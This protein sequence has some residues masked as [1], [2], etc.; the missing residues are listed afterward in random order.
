MSSLPFEVHEVLEQEYVAMYGDLEVP[1]PEYGPGDIIDEAWGRAVCDACSVDFGAGLVPALNALIAS[2]DLSHL[3]VSPAI[4]DTG[5]DLIDHYDDYT[6]GV[7]DARRREINRRIVDD[8]FLG[9][10]KLHRDTRLSALYKKLHAREDADARTALCISG[11]GIRT[12]TFA[13]GIIQG[14]AGARILDKFDYLSTVSGGGYIG[15]WL[16]SWARRHPSGIAGVQNDLV[17]A[18]TAV[19]GIQPKTPKSDRPTKKIDP[20][21]RPLRHLRAYSNYMSPKLG[22]LSAD[23]WTM[24]S[25]Y[26]RNLL[27]NLLVLIPI[28]AAV[29]AIPR[30]FAMLLR[31]DTQF[32]QHT[33]LV[34][35]A[36]ALAVG[37]GYLGLSRPTVHGR[38]ASAQSLRG[39]GGFFVFSV[40]P[41]TV[42][43]TAVS[44][45]WA[46]IAE[47]PFKPIWDRD[48]I[49]YAICAAAMTLLPAAIYYYRFFVTSSAAER[50]EPLERQHGVAK[51]LATELVATLT[52]LASVVTLF[53]LVANK[54]FDRPV[55]EVPDLSGIAP[56]LRGLFDST[57]VSELYVCFAVPIGLLIFF[58][59]NAAFVG[60]SSKVNEDYDREW[61]GRGG[62]LLLMT[63]VILALGCFVAVFGPV[64]LYRA[65]VIVSSIGGVSGI[66][67]GL[68]GFSSSTPANDK[69]KDEKATKSSAAS[70]IGLALAVPLFVIALLAGIS[71]G[72][73]VLIQ[74]FRDQK[75]SVA[76]KWVEQFQSNATLT[77][78]TQQTPDAKL[79]TKYETEKV[80]FLSLATVNG[81]QHLKT[82]H[83]TNRWDLL[84]ILGVALA[85]AGL[86]TL[87]GVNRFS[88]Q[89]LYRNRLIR[90]YLGASRYTRDAD[91]FTGF[92][93]HDNLQMYE[94]QPDLLWP[95]SFIDFPAFVAQLMANFITPGSVEQTIWN[96]LD[97]KTRGWL[98]EKRAVNDA[99]KNAMMQNLN[100][101]LMREGLG[102]GIEGEPSAPRLR[103]NRVTLQATFGKSLRERQ[104]APL[105]VINTA[106]NLT[107]GQKLAW[108]QRQAESFTVS[109][110][111]SGSFYVG[112]RDSKEYGG[113]DGI[114]IGTAVAISGAAAS[115]NQ[116]YHSSPAMAFI[117]TI[118][119]VRLGSWLGNPG[120]AGRN[121]YDNAHPRTNLE[122]LVWELTGTSND[123]CPLVYLSDG[124][125]FENLGIYEMVLRRCRFIVISDGG[126]DPK[127]SF[128]DLGNAIRKIRTD[129]GV[130]IDIEYDDM[131]PRSPDSTLTKGRYVT[132][133]RI[134]YSA[135][136]DTD[137][138]GWL[139]YIKPGLYEGEY[140]PKDVYNY[141]TESLDFPHESTADQFFSESQF[142]SYRAL[143]RHAFN[144]I[145]GNYK[146]G[147]NTYAN[148][149]PTVAAFKDAVKKNTPKMPPENLIADRINDLTTAMIRIGPPPP[150][151]PA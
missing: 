148:T 8:A 35:T 111:H 59:Q 119:N 136:D 139:V 107:S 51:K 106:L 147:A 123:Q 33:L 125:H 3:R 57:P 104:H 52:G 151:P 150:P 40:I 19:E 80:P 10:V 4:T 89:A 96:A 43:S 144:E 115:P 86:S 97:K 76:T 133:A 2:R 132:T 140:F 58:V 30:L 25:M 77:Q 44:L 13:L 64:L 99:L 149:Y 9:A 7:T 55:R 126:C 101:I 110:L 61:W 66:L 60:I 50:R 68:L 135:L 29:L 69:K 16:S 88:M 67:A 36:A 15:S 79:E 112:Y 73:T 116:G 109:P 98:E 113:K 31:H 146:T 71:L 75:V 108:Q 34:V 56:F 32:P 39:T 134:R 127:C 92:D 46:K 1:P 70:G 84:G 49:F 27:L 20:E 21:P 78:T 131:H 47:H 38:H 87:V 74:L 65:P 93:P 130:P 11:G 14:L 28:L 143:G 138:D 72:T 129:L 41:L 62:A 114:S 82:V 81:V 95:T 6:N 18:D 26:V 105:H 45:Y 137:K 24:A 117:L 54:V 5:C 83:A 23:T 124:G 145:C 48:W 122:P 94:L 85:A 22:F 142:E 100:R 121:T 102:G 90:A 91:E 118:L 17:R 128:E 12:A 42:A 103:R 120:L 53:Y 37:F 63:A 141:A